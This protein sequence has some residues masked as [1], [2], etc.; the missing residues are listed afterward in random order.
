MHI[1]DDFVKDVV[2]AKNL[3][4]RTIW[5]RELVLDKEKE[6]QKGTRFDNINISNQDKSP[7][8]LANMGETT[9][10]K[11]QDKQPLETKETAAKKKS[12]EEVLVDFQKRIGEQ[13]VVKMAVGADEYLA[14]TI[15]KDFADAVID[16][17]GHV[18]DV[19]KEWNTQ[20]KELMD[21]EAAPIETEQSANANQTPKTMAETASTSLAANNESDNDDELMKK[22]KFCVFCGTKVPFVAIFCSNCSRKQPQMDESGM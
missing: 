17:F 9:T 6:K 13:K 18:A 21:E 11:I 15:Q 19:L 14:D 10:T 3:N 16:N 12:P 22:T 4:M 5:A 7:D 2:P 1:G 20:Q 8:L